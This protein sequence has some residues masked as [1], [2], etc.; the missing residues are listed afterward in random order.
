[1]VWGQCKGGGN[2]V[3]VVCVC[4]VWAVCVCVCGGQAVVGAVCGVCVWG[5]RKA[6]VCGRG[7]VLPTSAC[8]PTE[9]QVCGNVLQGG[10]QCAKRGELIA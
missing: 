7:G 4:G 1:V 8:R 5:G 10:G 6:K 9:Q 2:V 3:G